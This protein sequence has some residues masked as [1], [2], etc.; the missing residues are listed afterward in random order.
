V[1][2]TYPAESDGER[3]APGRFK[4]IDREWDVFVAD[5]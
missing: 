2:A 3:R 4:G 1:P 5:R